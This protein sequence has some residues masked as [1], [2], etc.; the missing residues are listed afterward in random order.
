MPGSARNCQPAASGIAAGR[1]GA[2]RGVRSPGDEQH[3]HADERG[4]A[5]DLLRA[6]DHPSNDRGFPDGSVRVQSPA[7][8]V[9][10]S[11][12]GDTVR[13]FVSA[14]E[15]FLDN[16]TQLRFG[17]LAL[18]LVC[19]GLYQLVRSRSSYNA[20][21]AAYPDARFSWRKVWGAYVAAFGLNG[22]VPAG[23]GSVVQLVLTRNAIAGSSLSTVAS[24][25][26]VGVLFDG[27][28]CVGILIY[29]F[30][31]GVF[32]KPSDFG[33][34][35]SFDIAF[36]ARNP[37]LTLFL[38][39]AV[40]VV[41]LVGFAVLSRRI[42]AFWNTCAR[43]MGDPRRS[44]PLP[45]RHVP[46]PG[47]RRDPPRRRLLL[48]AR[49]LPRRRQRR[50]R[51]PRP[52]RP[53]HRRDRPVHPGGAGVQQALLVVIFSSTAPTTRS[54]CSR[55]AS[56]S[57]CSPSPSSRASRRSSSFSSTA[58]P[59]GVARQPR[60]SRQVSDALDT[61]CIP[62]GFPLVSRQLAGETGGG[63]HGQDRDSGATGKQAGRDAGAG[64]RLGGAARPATASADDSTF[65]CDALAVRAQLLQITPIV[66]GTANAGATTCS[67]V[68]GTVISIPP[69]LGL[70]INGGILV[71]KTGVTPD[72]QTASSVAALTG[73]G[74][75]L[76]NT[77]LSSITGPI[78]QQLTG[79]SAPIPLSD[80]LVASLLATLGLGPSTPTITSGDLAGGLQQILNTLLSNVLNGSIAGVGATAAS[81]STTC[82][83]GA[84]VL[85]GTSQITGLTVL[86]TNLPLDA[87]TNQAL[88]LL[89]TG[90]LQNL[91]LTTTLQQLVANLETALGVTAALQNNP[92]L[93]NTVNQLTNEPSPWPGASSSPSSPA[94]SRPRSR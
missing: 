16:L 11:S 12:I 80:S 78:S 67:N 70:P 23:G 20:L 90:Q 10:V 17:S 2:P 82:V 51:R 71:A 29:A 19:C 13:A 5:S 38:L 62:P 48:P 43:R 28:V 54:P 66:L 15:Q 94:C 68:D 93:I 83:N 91:N 57:P 31:R 1:A 79:S 21:R 63:N 39:T 61:C 84:P 69:N 64:H 45:A 6:A 14:A 4:G 32:P 72:G 41:G 42:A 24:A 81:A 88:N 27:V 30:T 22:V 86:G 18:A 37:Q 50:R 8:P 77:V 33:G 52:R 53:G 75:G 74:V 46:A 65:N 55:S 49:R 85:K 56:R 76:G 7:M 87:V 58:D 36:F 89:N 26:C 59:R 34:L 47:V 25:L 44:P 92:G 60:R 3:Q 40:V 9:I 73:L 35:S